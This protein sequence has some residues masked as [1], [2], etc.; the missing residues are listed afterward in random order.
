MEVPSRSSLRVKLIELDA[1]GA[2]LARQWFQT[3]RPKTQ[4]CRP[5]EDRSDEEILARFR[6]RQESETAREFG[7]HL[8][9]D[10]RLI[11]KVSYFDL[12]TRNRS[13][14]IGFILDPEFRRQSYASEALGLFLDYLF[15][16]RQLNKVMAQTGEFNHASI[17]LLKRWGF[18]QD[19]QLR[20]HHEVDGVL[21]DDLLFSLLAEEFRKK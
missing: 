19:G 9:L 11:G 14:E 13:V 18:S 20:Q 1:A 4:T 16:K 6:K 17:T 10:N 8:A 7:I 15:D 21:H 2:M 12:N 3:S 5:L